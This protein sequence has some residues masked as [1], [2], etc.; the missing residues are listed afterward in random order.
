MSGLSEMQ[1]LERRNKI[2]EYLASQFDEF[3]VINSV[4]NVD[5]GRPPLW[6]LGKSV[7]LLSEA[8]LAVF[9]TDW[10]KSRGCRIEFECCRQYD[11]KMLFI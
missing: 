8:N 6:Y 2:I 5:E 9:D 4:L 1:I 3:E 10:F 11:I 7:E